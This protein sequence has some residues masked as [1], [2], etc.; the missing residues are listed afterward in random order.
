[1]SVNIQHIKLLEHKNRKA[2]FSV[3]LSEGKNKVI[4]PKVLAI[5]GSRGIF[6]EPY[7]RNIKD[8]NKG[9]AWKT[10]PYYYWNKDLKAAAE[11]LIVEHLDEL[12]KK[13]K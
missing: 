1:M 3:V 4:L 13:K 9:N 12:D 11:K 7:S 5:A 2:E 8:K 6:C 10:L